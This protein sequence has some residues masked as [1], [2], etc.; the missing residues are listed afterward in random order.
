MFLNLIDGRRPAFIALLLASFPACPVA[1]SAQTAA[2]GGS[3]MLN[4]QAATT[5]FKKAG[6]FVAEE[7]YTEAKNELGVAASTLPAPYNKMAIEFVTQLESGLNVSTNRADARRVHALVELCSELRA[8]QAVLQLR[9]K[10][11]D[12]GGT[13]SDDPLYAWR[14]FESGDAK[15]ALAE[16]ERKAAKE[17]IDTWQTYYQV[18]ARILRERA[19]NPTN[20][21]PAID[22]VKE[23][24]LKSLETHADL[25]GAMTELTRALP[26]ATDSKNAI[27]IYQLILKCLAGLGDDE[28]RAAWQDKFLANFKSDP[29]VSAEVYSDKGKKAYYKK[30]IQG[31]QAFFQKV[32]SEYPD[33][34]AYGD[35]QYGLGLVLQEQQKCDEAIKEY[36]KL[37]PSKVNDYALDPENSEDCANYR[38]KAALRISECYE[39]KKDFVRALEYAKMARDRYKFMSYCKDC[40]RDTRKNV[41]QRVLRIEELAKKVE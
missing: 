37:F 7:K 17:I 3:A 25:F 11:P 27:L 5:A 23:H 15:G 9:S 16:Y 40:L 28:G 32:C 19:A 35:A 18:Q 21:Q 34:G 8:H 20:A 36:S 26:Y 30:N 13:A 22:L 29:E 38:F 4:W 6:A 14:L 31:A 39:Q 10:Y 12:A 24:Y 33:S 41:E 2:D 1:L